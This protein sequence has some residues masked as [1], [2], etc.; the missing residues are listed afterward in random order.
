MRL[1]SWG[2]IEGRMMSQVSN[3]WD[4]NEEGFAGTSL[5]L[6]RVQSQENSLKSSKGR[7][8]KSSRRGGGE[9]MDAGQI[10]ASNERHQRQNNKAEV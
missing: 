4:G 1:R 3:G 10:E 9:G 7:G 5:N 2:V 8:A 6:R